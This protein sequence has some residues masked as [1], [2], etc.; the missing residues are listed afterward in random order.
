[1]FHDVAWK[2]KLGQKWNQKQMQYCT[3]Q[4][5]SIWDAT[6]DAESHCNHRIANTAALQHKAFHKINRQARSFSL[7]CQ[8]NV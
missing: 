5:K 6:L 2:P 7:H 1:M 4:S 3:D 8:S